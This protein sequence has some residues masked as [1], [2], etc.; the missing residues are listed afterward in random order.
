VC[1]WIGNIEMVARDHD[2]QITEEHFVRAAGG[3]ETKGDAESGAA[4]ARSDSQAV[5]PSSDDMSA[6]SEIADSNDE[7]RDG[8]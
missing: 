1:S 6:T 5:A 8:A 7:V 3:E 4:S 2:L